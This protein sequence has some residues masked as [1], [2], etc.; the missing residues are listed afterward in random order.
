MQLRTALA[1]VVAAGIGA[2]SSAA[3]GQ[4]A[5]EESIDIDILFSYYD[6]DGDHSPVTGGIGTEA[7][8]VV[9]PVVVVTWRRDEK[10]TFSGDLGV[11]QMSSASIGNIQMELSSASIPSA[12]TRFFT[13]LKATRSFGRQA[14]GL[15]IGA[16]GEYDYES[17]SYGLDWT[18]A[19]NR[20]N[21]AISAAVRRYDDAI[22]LIG[23]DGNGYQGEGLPITAGTADRTTTDL[24]LSVSQTL[25]R[26]TAGSIELFVSQQEGFLSTPFHEIIL[27]ADASHTDGR[28]VAER[29]PDSRDRQAVSLKLNHAFHDRIVQRV[30]YRHYSDDWGITAHTVDLETHFRLAGDLQMWVYPIL[31]YHTQSGADWFGLPATFSGAE[32]YRTSDWDLAETTTNKYGVGWSVTA[33]PQQEWI[34]RLD[35]FEV[36]G[37]VYDRDDGLRGFTTSFGFGWTF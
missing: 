22:E 5:P 23:L 37:T 14:V 30:G 3:L 31:R 15:T 8:Q 20:D 10:W 35:R 34:W 16:A 26:R 2:F 11:D 25:G 21:T 18:I 1:F 9:S 33:P 32:D 17:L 6:Q 36:R 4:T 12:D 7:L 19:L 27:A 24:F 13:N 29:L 28:I